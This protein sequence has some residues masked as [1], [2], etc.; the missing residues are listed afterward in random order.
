[1][2]VTPK[3]FIIALLGIFVLQLP[4]QESIDTCTSGYLLVKNSSLTSKDDLYRHYEALNG[5]IVDCQYEDTLWIE[6]VIHKAVELEDSLLNASFH[7]SYYLLLYNKE[8]YQDAL[9]Y[10]KIL[11]QFAD[12]YNHPLSGDF[13]IEAGINYSFKGDFSNEYKMFN[14]AIEAYKRDN[15]E[16]LTYALS[17][18]G[19]FYQG[20]GDFDKALELHHQAYKSAQE[21]ELEHVKFYNTTNKLFSIARNHAL[22]N[23]IDSAKIYFKRAIVDGKKQRNEDLMLTVYADYILFLTKIKK[24]QKAD[25]VLIEANAFF[26]DPYFSNKFKTEYISYFKFSKSKLYLEKGEINQCNLPA[27]LLKAELSNANK[28]EILQYGIDYSIEKEDLESAFNF[29]QELKKLINDE[30]ELQRK[31]ALAFIEEKQKSTQL[32]EENYKLTEKNKNRENFLKLLFTLVS[33]LGLILFLLYRTNRKS[34][35]LN[36]EIAEKNNQISSQYSELERISYVMT[37]DLKEPVK[38]VQSFSNLLANNSETNFSSK[39]EKI[40]EVIENASNGMLESINNLHEYLILGRKSILRLINLNDV[41]K[42]VLDNLSGIIEEKKAKIVYGKLP[43]IRAFQKEITTLFQNL[44]SNSLKYSQDHMAPIIQI[45]VKET[46]EHYQFSVIDNGIGIPKEEHKNIFDLFNRLHL[47]TKIEGSGIGL[48]HARKV[49][50]MHKGKIWLESI[51]N[52]GSKF[53][54]TISKKIS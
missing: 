22:Q 37:H 10:S 25:K 18:L 20:I 23:N 39:E 42:Q 40:I 38:T 47:Q 2:S 43:E 9:K 24:F 19:N 44:I 41:V 8:R 26:T 16:N 1:M 3:V 53:H 33:A 12:K 15:S 28:K 17:N 29:S 13:Y 34:K 46:K 11:I 7:W 49:V 48:T 54:F 50:E 30:A 6:K 32:L 5:I 31:S 4:A 52:Q 36:E 14:Q 35:K 45:K 51:P 27:D 21:M